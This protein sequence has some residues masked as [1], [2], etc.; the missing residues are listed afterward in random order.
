MNKSFKGGRSA[1]AGARPRGAAAGDL[2][3]EASRLLARL[4]EPGAYARPDPLVEEALV[5][6]RGGDGISVG[7]GRFAAASGRALAAADLATWNAAGTRLTI[8]E[9][10]R[11]RLRR[12]ARPG[13]LAFADQHREL[14]VVQ[15]GAGPTLRNAAENP[16]AWMVR[17][18][19]RDGA[20]LIDAA[21]FEA[22]ERLR[23]DMTAAALLPRMGADLGAPRID[24]GGPRDPAS[25]A[26]HVIAARQ[27]VRGAL[28]AV[29]SDLSG[30]LIDLCGFLK[31]LERI[32]AERRWPARSAKVVARIALGRLAEHYGLER[33]ATGPDRARLRLWRG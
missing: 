6:R 29:G 19:D 20:P 30:L 18:R 1:T 17:R 3:A 7:S 2:P 22:G 31:G 15:G 21:A 14:A 12:E 33:E 25:A 32:E 11:A 5:T 4:G 13:D 27:R 16:L 26:D 10:G 8:S 23:R 9:A 24:G 28:D